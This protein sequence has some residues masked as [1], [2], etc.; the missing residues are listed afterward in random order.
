MPSNTLRSNGPNGISH[1]NQHC[2]AECVYHTERATSLNEERADRRGE[3][4][5]NPRTTKNSMREVPLAP[6]ENEGSQSHR[7]QRYREVEQYV[8]RSLRERIDS[9]RLRKHKEVDYSEET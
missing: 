2:N 1:G 3:H 7:T 6:Y 4:E 9:K 8:S 5:Q